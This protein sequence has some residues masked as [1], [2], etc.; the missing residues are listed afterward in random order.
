MQ[1]TPNEILNYTEFNNKGKRVMKKNTPVDIIKKA[2]SWERDFYSKT[3]RRRI[4][5]LDIDEASVEFV[6]KNKQGDHY[7]ER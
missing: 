5:D 2:I 7:G 6:F 1:K 3:G 4:V